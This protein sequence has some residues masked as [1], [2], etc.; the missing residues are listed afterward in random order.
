MVLKDGSIFEKH[1]LTPKGDPANPLTFEEVEAK[2]RD[3]A[4][5]VIGGAKAARIVDM[6][7]GLE[8]LDDSTRL[9]RLCC[10]KGSETL[11]QRRALS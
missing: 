1:A 8:T 3:L 4:G 10:A 9:L 11:R 5:P 2:F 7:H 6:V